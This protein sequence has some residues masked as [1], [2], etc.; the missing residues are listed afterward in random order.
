MSILHPVDTYIPGQVGM[1][2]N[3][4]VMTPSYHNVKKMGVHERNGMGQVL[5]AWDNFR[6]NWHYRISGNNENWKKI[7]ILRN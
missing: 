6:D 3:T 7:T 4:F 5:L 1:Q 2:P